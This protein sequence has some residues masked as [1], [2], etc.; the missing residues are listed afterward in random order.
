MDAVMHHRC[1]FV[2]HSFRHV[3]PMK[4][5]RHTLR[6]TM[7]K[8]LVSLTRRA[9]AFRRGCNLSFVAF[10]AIVVDVGHNKGMN[11]HCR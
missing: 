3:K 4:V 10:G 9:A 11:E 2:L 5:D 7:I 1:E 8:L 6:Q